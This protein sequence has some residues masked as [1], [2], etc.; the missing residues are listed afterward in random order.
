MLIDGHVLLAWLQ[1]SGLSAT[2]IASIQN[3]HNDVFVSAATLWQ[4]A[5]KQSSGRLTIDGDLREHVRGQRFD[6]LPVTGE[7]AVAVTTLPPGHGDL[8]ARML[9]AQARY[10]G[11]TLVTVDRRL[12]TYG[13]QILST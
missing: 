1:G 12:R 9:V 5:I 13:I 6:E 11:L 4:L 10:E 3:R 2:A 7:H 8:F